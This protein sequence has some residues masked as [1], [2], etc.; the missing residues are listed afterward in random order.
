MSPAVHLVRMRVVFAC[1]LIF[2]GSATAASG[3][4]ARTEVQKI[5]AF[6]GR[7]REYFGQYALVQGDRAIVGAPRAQSDGAA[8]IYRRQSGFRGVIW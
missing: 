8:Y 3:Q 2:V 5:V 4:C 1:V 6:D 7:S